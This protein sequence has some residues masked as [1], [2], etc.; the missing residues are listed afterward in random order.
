MTDQPLPLPTP[1]Q[2][3]LPR[4]PRTGDHETIS[5]A[6]TSILPEIIEWMGPDYDESKKADIEE[7]LIEAMKDNPGLD[8]YDLAK[9]LDDR[10]RWEC[11]AELV[12]ILDSALS[13][14]GSIR[15]RRIEEWV[16]ANGIHPKLEIGR[17]I[18]SFLF[19]G[20]GTITAIKENRA[21]YVVKNDEFEKQH[22]D[23]PATS[24]F[25]VPYELATA[26]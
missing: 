3:N 1:E 20:E 15:D 11:D 19:S 12:E 8:G 25:L 2:P 13:C 17:K 6:A 16:K 21:C 5:A 26:I 7:H 18:T 9:F 14:A 22:P 4:R 24:G 10:F 23:Q